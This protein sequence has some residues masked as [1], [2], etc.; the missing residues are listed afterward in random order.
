MEFKCEKDGCDANCSEYI[1]TTVNEVLS[2]GE[3]IVYPTETLYGLGGNPSEEG[4]MDKIREVKEAPP[5]KKIS[6][7]YSNLDHASE[8]MDLPD[9]AWELG[10][11]FLPGPLTLVID[12]SEG[13]EGI[14]VP[15]HPLAQKIIEDFGPIT[16]TSANIHGR[17]APMEIKTA[18]IQLD[19]R[20]KL[21]V[22]C[23]RC[24]YGKGSTVVKVGEDIEILREGMISPKEIGDKIGF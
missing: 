23:G 9:L 14:R 7:A 16:S 8:Y 5:D 21:Y 18:K 6:I 1:I 2:N 10:E 17:P 11:E 20:V 4:M 19:G 15:D 24:E 3:L 12:T 13:T 22:N